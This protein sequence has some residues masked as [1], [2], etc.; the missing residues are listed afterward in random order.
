MDRIIYHNM[1]NLLVGND[2]NFHVQLI[3]DIGLFYEILFLI[4]EQNQDYW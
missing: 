4:Y 3:P 2:L 1:H